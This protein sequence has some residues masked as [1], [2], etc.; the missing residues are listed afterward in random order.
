MFESRISRFL[1]RF[2]LLKVRVLNPWVLSMLGVEYAG[3]PSLNDRDNPGMG[4]SIPCPGEGVKK[5][6]C[7]GTQVNSVSV[8]LFYT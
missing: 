4:T 7:P 2:P 1:V 5:L 6:N 3:Q 8:E